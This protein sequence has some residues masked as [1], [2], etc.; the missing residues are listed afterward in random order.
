MK[1]T[2]C[3]WKTRRAPRQRDGGSQQNAWGLGCR[4]AA[5]QGTESEPGANEL[6]FELEILSHH[7]NGLHRFHIQETQHLKKPREVIS[8][9]GNIVLIIR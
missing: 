9:H 3:S 1:S 5:G 4:Q 2:C 7:C 8:Q 6:L